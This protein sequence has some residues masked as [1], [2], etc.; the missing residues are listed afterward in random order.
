MD[1]YGLIGYPLGHSFSVTYFN[2]KF[3]SENIDAE[4][5][6]FEIPRIED[7][8]EVVTENINLCGLNVTIPYKEQVIPYLDELDPDT[9]KIGAVN[10]IKIIRQGKAKVKLVGYN[11]DIIGFTQSIEPL[12]QPHHTK[13]LLLGTGGASKAVFH[14]LANL[15]IE[16]LY[17]SRSKRDAE[18]LTYA[19]LTPEVMAEHTIIVNCTPVG[20]YPKVDFCPDIPYEQLTPQHLLYDLLYNPNETLFMKK[21]RAQGA[22]VKNGL[23]MLLLQAFAAWEIWHR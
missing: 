4:Y 23:E 3:Q 20:M 7:F 8:P 15:G 22:T 21:G 14:G 19:D 12:L 5:V 10:V 1:K 17:V 9:A 2:E 6:N 11:S 13:A 16:S 18:T